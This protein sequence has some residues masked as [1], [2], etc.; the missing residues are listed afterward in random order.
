MVRLQHLLGLKDLGHDVFLLEILRST[1][2][3]HHDQ[4]CIKSFFEGLQRYGLNDQCALLLYDK[5]AG[6]RFESADVY[7][8]NRRE[9]RDTI[10]DADLLW[11]DCCGVR[12]PLLGMFRHR[13]LIDLDPGHL[14]VSALTVNMDLQYHDTFLTV[15]Q[16]LHDADCEVPTLG[17]SWHPFAPV[18]YLSMWDFAPDPG[19]EAPFSSITHWTWAELWLQD[20]VL[21]IS[22]R[23]AY[24]RYLELPRQTMRPFE[25]AANIHPEDQ[26]GDRE[27]L[28]S[29][30]W[31]L[32][33]PWQV[34]G[35]PQA[36][37]RYIAR[38]RAEISCPKPIF[39][40]LKSGWFSDRSAAYLASGRPVLAEDTGFS[41]HFPTGEGLLVFN[42]LSEVIAGVAA[43]DA[44]YERHRRAAREFA[45]EYV[46]SRRVLE[47][48]LAACG[49]AV[50][51]V[52]EQ[53]GHR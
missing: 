28:R 44:N 51:N 35:S 10:K 25:L 24:L 2:D 20:R 5:A 7:G 53:R 6:Q 47:T 48:M 8:K 30:G 13:V 50:S 18:I 36:Y 22:K 49:Q 40:E 32:V 52:P 11:N 38:S 1:G 37:Q 46:D 43:I 16:K 19:R 41:D 45:E 21:S 15:G 34:A 9:V 12:Q 14:Q 4:Q 29:H 33:D 27:L 23:D 26:T 3:A 17:F 39:R 42:D 31:E